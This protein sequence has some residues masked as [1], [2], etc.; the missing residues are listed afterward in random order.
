LIHPHLK[1]S[2]TLVDSA[3]T[4][5]GNTTLKYLGLPFNRGISDLSVFAMKEMIRASG[6]EQINFDETS[7]SDMKEKE[8]DILIKI[9]KRMREETEEWPSSD[10]PKMSLCDND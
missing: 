7:I 8:L 1:F 9:K 6:I 2:S 10:G 5:V 3:N 4:H